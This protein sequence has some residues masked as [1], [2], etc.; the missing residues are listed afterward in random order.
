MTG[1]LYPYVESFHSIFGCFDLPGAQAALAA[2]CV[3][4]AMEHV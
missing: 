4:S 2:V 3:N 1:T